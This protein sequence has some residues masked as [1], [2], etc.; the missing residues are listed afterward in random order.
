MNQESEAGRDLKS[1]RAL[2]L[3]NKSSQGRMLTS[4]EMYLFNRGELYHS[5]YKFGAHIIKEQGQWGT[6]F[7]LWAPYAKQVWVVGDFND[8]DGRKHPMEKW[9]DHGIWTLFIPGLEEGE[10]Y[11]YKI[12]TSEGKV[13]LKGDPFAF[14]AEFRPQTASK[15]ATLE[16]YLWGDQEWLTERKSREYLEEPMVIYELHLGSW[17]RNGED[18]LSYKEIS[19]QLID[20]VKKMGFTHIEILPLME[21]PYDGSWG[22]QVTGYYAC[23]SRYG[24]PEE[25]M[26]LIDLC[27]QAGIGVILDW[28]PGHF[29]PD[30][31]GLALFDGT[32]LYEAELHDHWGTYKFDF[33]RR[34]VWSFLIS[35]AVFWFDIFHVDGLRVDGVSSML[36]LDYGKE[37]QTWQANEFGGRENLEAINFLRHL[38]QVVHTYY[39][40]VLMIAEE[41]TPWPG[42]TKPVSEGGLGFDFKWNMGWMND[43]LKYISHDFSERRSFHQLLTFPMMYAYEESFILPLSHDEVVHGKRSLLNKMPGDYWEKFAGLRALYSYFICYPG[44]KL[45]FMGAE[46]AQFIEWREERELDWFLLDFE[47]H[48]KFQ[49]FVQRLNN[50]YLQERA[51]WEKDQNYTG[52]EWIDV[53]NHE[54]GIIV[55]SRKGLEPEDYLIVLINFLPKQY[56][57]Y[58]I[59]VRKAS[60]YE[61]ILN[62]DAQEY[63]GHG[64]TNQGVIP[65]EDTPWHGRS[66]SILLEIPPLAA[67]L[68]KPCPDQSQRE[69]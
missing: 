34:E 40:D 68:L 10:I 22:Y 47:L 3:D 35:N 66:H 38:N 27:H 50:S 31:H 6:Y 62:S 14:H 43:T 51:L 64:Y 49:C 54:Q 17:R 61:E 15:I 39:P 48:R 46:I 13:Q 52:F 28:V 45:L 44:K 33:S 56:S 11:K 5:Y 16:G 7:A 37:N 63:G 8:W 20:Y 12:L 36:Y 23:T 26:I 55:F 29:C 24:T 42:V 4:S 59:G 32:A 41:A 69:H 58:R 60:G 65:V 21:H 30:S 53:H 1:I 67:I 19:S 18:F 25:L 57:K 9:V 2:N